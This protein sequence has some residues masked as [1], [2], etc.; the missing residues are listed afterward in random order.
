MTGHCT[1][2]GVHCNCCLHWQMLQD[3]NQWV[4][5]QWIGNFAGLFLNQLSCITYTEEKY[6]P[7]KQNYLNVL[8]LTKPS[9][10][11]QN[12]HSHPCHGTL[13]QY[14]PSCFA[15]RTY[16]NIDVHSQNSIAIHVFTY[17]WYSTV[18]ENIFMLS[19]SCICWTRIMWDVFQVTTEHS[20]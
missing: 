13:L 1:P 11:W 12:C 3:V 9:M 19:K 16:H 4:H 5:L 17:L 18:S 7:H 14:A 10:S 2:L 6:M 15:L 8:K 20:T